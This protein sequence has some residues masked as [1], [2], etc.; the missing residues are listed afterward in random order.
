M[1]NKPIKIQRTHSH[2]I[3]AIW[4]NHHRR[5]R[6]RQVCTLQIIH[7]SFEW[8]CFS[9]VLFFISFHSS[10]YGVLWHSFHFK[11]VI[12]FNKLCLCDSVPN[13]GW[14]LNVPSIKSIIRWEFSLENCA[15]QSASWMHL[16]FPFTYTLSQLH[17]QIH[18]H[19]RLDMYVCN[20]LP[21]DSWPHSFNVHLA[22]VSI[23]FTLIRVRHYQIRCL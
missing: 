21:I 14:Y 15:R 16:H 23:S 7:I 9:N 13:L 6:R 19:S 10:N 17:M 3:Y 18:L 5:R 22:N 1:R 2:R 4:Y 12:D 11:I 8:S 20:K